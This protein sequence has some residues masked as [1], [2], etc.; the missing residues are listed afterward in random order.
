MAKNPNRDAR[1]TAVASERGTVS[2]EPQPHAGWPSVPPTSPVAP[3]AP[4]IPYPPVPY[5]VAALP[6]PY[7]PRAGYP[8]PAAPPGVPLPTAP[9]TFPVP[10]RVD[11]VP[12]TPFGL[13]YLGVSPTVSGAGVGSLVA[14]IGSDLVATLVLAFGLGG[15]QD[16]WGVLVGGAFAILAGL[17]GLGAVGLGLLGLRQVTLAGGRVRGRGLAVA[18]IACGGT[19]VVLTA[20]AMLGTLLLSG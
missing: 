4:P 9:P 19:G 1:T 3:A 10:E 16:G 15:A 13:A 11:P 20:S 2:E 6:A 14:G 5:P 8:Y 7:P 18:G 17:V 12:G